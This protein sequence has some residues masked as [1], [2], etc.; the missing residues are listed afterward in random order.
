MVN[1]I[2]QHHF[3][4]GLVRTPS[5]FG[6]LGE[7]P[8]HPELLD[9]LG[10]RFIESGWSVKA[11]HRD[12]ILSATYQ[13]T[14]AFSPGS[15]N[16]ANDAPGT[17]RQNGGDTSPRFSEPGLNDPLAVDAENKLLWRMNRRRLEVEAWRDAMLAVAGTLDQ[18]VGGPSGDLNAADN[19]RRTLYGSVSR[20][21]LNPLL[22]LFDFPDPNI[23][24]DER[25]LTTVPLQQLF[26]LNSEFMVQ[27]AKALVSR[28]EKIADDEDRVRH[29]FTLVYGRPATQRELDL[30]VSFLSQASGDGVGLS[31]WQ[32]YAQV[33]LSANEFLYLD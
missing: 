20:H 10:A 17:T 12:I 9:W 6:E 28:L 27:S 15:K 5:N 11:L 19:R 3:G 33:L 23:T 7:R 18:T 14:S 31:R 32:Q 16:R 21:D 1:R 2:W 8:T 4:K 13:Q 24:S 26:V 30:A 29:A 25:T 22:R